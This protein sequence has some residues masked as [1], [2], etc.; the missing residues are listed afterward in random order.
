MPTKE[1]PFST[2]IF[3]KEEIRDAR[4]WFTQK[5]NSLAGEVPK[6]ITMSD[7]RYRGQ[8]P[9]A[10][11]M[12]YY[13]YKAKWDKILPYWDK[14]PLVIVIKEN[15]KYMQ[16]LNLHYLPPKLRVIFMKALMDTINNDQMNSTTK[17]KITND[18]LKAASK[19]RY[20]KPCIKLYLKSHVK[21]NVM[22]IRTE[23]WHKAIALPVANFKGATVTQ[24][25]NDSRKK[26]QR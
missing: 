26:Y 1:N 20:F 5:V 17:F 22:V 6:D 14:F 19:Y 13:A 2:K 7:L 23:Q 11:R 12:I 21:S 3:R 8:Y 4:K 16:G 25:W 24:V 10:G 15:S 18:I 9:L